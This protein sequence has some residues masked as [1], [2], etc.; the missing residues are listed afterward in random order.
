MR[1]SVDVNRL[2]GVMGHYDAVTQSTT[3]VR[4]SVRCFLN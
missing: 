1:T 2:D 4:M 3:V